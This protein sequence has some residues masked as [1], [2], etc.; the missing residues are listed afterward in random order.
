MRI[1]EERDYHNKEAE[2][3]NWAS[4]Y[5]SGISGIYSPEELPKEM[6]DFCVSQFER[7]NMPVP[8]E[9]VILRGMWAAFITV[10]YYDPYQLFYGETDVIYTDD[11]MHKTYRLDDDESDLDPDFLETFELLPD[12]DV[13]TFENYINNPGLEKIS[14]G[15][16]IEDHVAGELAYDHVKISDES[17]EWLKAHSPP[18]P[19]IPTMPKKLKNKDWVNT[20]ETYLKN[21][22]WVK[23]DDLLE[24]N[25]L[26]KDPEC[27][28]FLNK[29]IEYRKVTE[30]RTD[31][32][33]L[34]AW[35][36][37]VWFMGPLA[38]DFR[39]R[40]YEIFDIC[41]SDKSCI[42]YSGNMYSPTKFKIINR[43]PQ[44]CEICGLDSYCVSLAYFNGGSKFICE[45]HL[46]GE[47]P[48]FTQSSCGSRVCRFTECKHHPMF[49]MKDARRLAHR[50]SGQLIQKTREN[51][52]LL[53]NPD[54]PK[55]LN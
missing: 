39:R 11:W 29:A 20:Y 52:K 16:I 32:I 8:P 44:S 14:C 1:G 55:L 24:L 42:L 25:Q 46:N 40:N 45:K 34:A 28:E 3:L 13:K 51:A 31:Y 17:F 47:L 35:A 7:F 27:L 54:Q 10:D 49:G 18:E 12:Q 5:G 21:K 15:D 23:D 50:E 9:D 2:L 26:L 37:Y 38:R 36:A 33:R 53:N 48:Q 19:A 4:Y 43:S 6:F 41:Y 22:D 30:Y